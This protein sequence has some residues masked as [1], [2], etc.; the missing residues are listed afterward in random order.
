MQ[1]IFTD[2]C[3]LLSKHVRHIRLNIEKN[4]SLSLSFFQSLPLS[5][6]ISVHFSETLADFLHLP[7]SFPFCLSGKSHWIKEAQ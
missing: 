1:A 4:T 5:I 2:R 6:F 3:E 7:H